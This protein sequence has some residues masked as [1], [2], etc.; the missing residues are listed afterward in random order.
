M[1]A[2][3]WKQQAGIAVMCIV[4]VIASMLVLITTLK[5]ILL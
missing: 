5:S 1:E 3:N 2:L 4:S